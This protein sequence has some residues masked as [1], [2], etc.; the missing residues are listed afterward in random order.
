MGTRPSV[1]VTRRLPSSVIARL[2]EA[3]EVDLYTGNTA[4]S[5]DELLT[6]VAG[7]HALVCL[8]TDTVDAAVLSFTF[9]CPRN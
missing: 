4:I 5:R 3:C 8:L 7:K 9:S 2:E 6:R 1:L